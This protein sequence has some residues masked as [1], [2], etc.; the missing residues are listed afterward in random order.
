VLTLDRNG[1]VQG[2][3][4]LLGFGYESSQSEGL[5]T[6]D[7]HEV[8]NVRICERTGPPHGGFEREARSPTQAEC[9]YCDCMGAYYQP[10]YKTGQLARQRCDTPAVR[11]QRDIQMQGIECHNHRHCRQCASFAAPAQAIAIL[12]S[13]GLG[14][15]A[16]AGLEEDGH[17]R[18][19]L[20][21]IHFRDVSCCLRE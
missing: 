3:D 21:A 15:D 10:V 4:T 16:L 19:S 7:S 12:F 17:V 20:F 5:W 2:L 11:V 18:V 14:D 1:F 8:V 9:E 13:L 6:L